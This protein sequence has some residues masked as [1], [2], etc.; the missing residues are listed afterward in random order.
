MATRRQDQDFQI[1]IRIGQ[2]GLFFPPPVAYQTPTNTDF[3][4]TAHLLLSNQLFFNC[5]S[6]PTYPLSRLLSISANK[7]F[8]LF[9]GLMGA[10]QTSAASNCSINSVNTAF[11]ECKCLIAARAYT[12]RIIHPLNQFQKKIIYAPNPKIGILFPLQV[13]A[14]SPQGTS[15][16]KDQAPSLSQL[17]HRVQPDLAL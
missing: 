2:F 15:P 6:H 5:F 11:S 7:Y 3:P 16:R 10:S 8:S 1:K 9:H 13:W 17:G 4:R 14:I 12:H